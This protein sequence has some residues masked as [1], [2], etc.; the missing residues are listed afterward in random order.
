LRPCRFDP[1]PRAHRKR[2][3]HGRGY[4]AT[5]RHRRRRPNLARPKGIRG[6]RTPPAT[7]SRRRF[8]RACRRKE[9]RGGKAHS[10]TVRRRSFNQER[11]GEIRGRR[12]IETRGGQYQRWP[13]LNNAAPWSKI[14]ARCD[15]QGQW[16]MTGSGEDRRA[17]SKSGQVETRRA[18]QEAA[19]A[20]SAIEAGI[21]V[22]RA[23]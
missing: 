12:K 11:R 14:V 10:V 1:A 21:A 22:I 5:V 8:N 2:E 19:E 16:S 18:S 17:T 9:I 7:I 23:C 3:D 13:L 20:A 15:S 6:C 4:R